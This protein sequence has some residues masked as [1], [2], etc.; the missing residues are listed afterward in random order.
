MKLIIDIPKEVIVA[1]ENGLDYRYDIHTAIAQGAPYEERAHGKWKKIGEE[2]YNWSNHDTI[3]CNR[4]KFEKDI[5]C[6]SHLPNYCEACG[7][8]M[9]GGR[10]LVGE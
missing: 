9:R 4:C 5:P 3:K 7:A 8:D 2:Y 1:I 6:G 10:E